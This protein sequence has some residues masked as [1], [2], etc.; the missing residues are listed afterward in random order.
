MKDQ[1]VDPDEALQ[2]HRDVKSKLSL[3]IHWGSFELTDEPLDAPMGELAEAR[4]RH[5]VAQD[6]FVLF[7]HGETRRLVG[8]S[9]SNR[10]AETAR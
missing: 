2:I 10:A 7:R 4:Q 1:H 6:A 9:V 8:P 5:G 3:G